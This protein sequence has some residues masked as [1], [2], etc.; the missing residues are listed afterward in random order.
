M[1]PGAP[2]SFCILCQRQAPHYNQ[3]IRARSAACCQSL[4][5]LSPKFL[6]SCASF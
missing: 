2:F 5:V 4:A 3:L 6:N 1:F